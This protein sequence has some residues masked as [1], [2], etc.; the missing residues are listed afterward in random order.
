MRRIPNSKLH[1]LH[2]TLLGEHQQARLLKG[3]PYGRN[4]AILHKLLVVVDQVGRIADSSR[5][6]ATLSEAQTRLTHQQQK[7]EGVVGL[8]DDHHGG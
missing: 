5:K 3:L 8:P 2:P 4:L 6:Y 1:I 7:L